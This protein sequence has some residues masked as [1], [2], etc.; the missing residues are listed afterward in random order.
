MDLEKLNGITVTLC[1]E[2]SSKNH[3]TV[4]VSLD[5]NKLTVTGHDFGLT[6]LRMWGTNE[7]KYWYFFDEKNTEKL[8]NALYE[9]GFDPIEEMKNRFAGTS[10]CACLRMLCKEIGIEYRFDNLSVFSEDDLRLVDEDKPSEVS[11]F[12]SLKHAIDIKYEYD[13]HPIPK[14]TYDG[15]YKGLYGRNF[16][17]AYFKDRGIT[18]EE[19][20]WYDRWGGL[21]Y[22]G[23]T[24][25]MMANAEGMKYAKERADCIIA[26]RDVTADTIWKGSYPPPW[27]WNNAKDFQRVYDL[28]CIPD[29]IPVYRICECEYQGKSYYYGIGKEETPITEDMRVNGKWYVYTWAD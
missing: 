7:Y 18:D 8:M 12:V 4:I 17:I 3:F 14:S 20:E 1:D 5:D 11:T 21:P 26:Y 24:N 2:Q 22:G 16:L 23:P 19:I 6:P 25:R 9:S 28:R 13:S 27:E 29:K 15:P 10:A